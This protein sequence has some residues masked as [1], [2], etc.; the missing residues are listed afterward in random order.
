MITP[1]L[2]P[3]TTESTEGQVKPLTAAK[4]EFER[5]YLKEIDRKS[6][7]LNSSH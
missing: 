7:R 6:T 5:N 1:D 3:T 4:E 2:L